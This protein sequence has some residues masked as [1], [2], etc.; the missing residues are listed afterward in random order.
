MLPRRD[1]LQ[2]KNT[3]AE[4]EGIEKDVSSKWKLQESRDSNTHIKK[5]GINTK[6]MKKDKKEH[7]IM[8]KK[9]IQEDSIPTNIHAYRCTLN[10]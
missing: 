4:S 3:L 9:P 7:Y 10:I 5:I 6:D 8:M 1:S 2:G